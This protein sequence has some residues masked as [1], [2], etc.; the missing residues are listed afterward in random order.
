MTKFKT[1]RDGDVRRRE[2]ED[3]EPPAPNRVFRITDEERQKIAKALRFIDEARRELEHQQ[4]PDNREIIRELRTSADGIY[5]VVN[6][7]EELDPDG[8]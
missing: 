3:D 4:N 6:R 8:S 2:I 1:H 7:L 5:D